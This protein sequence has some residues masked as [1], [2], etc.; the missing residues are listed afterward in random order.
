MKNLLVATAALAT[1]ATAAPAAANQSGSS[2]TDV[3]VDASLAPSCSFG[4]MS[5]S[6]LNVLTLSNENRSAS[7]TVPYSCNFVGNPTVTIASQSG[8][9]MPNQTAS[10]NGA[11]NVLSYRIRFGDA[12]T[13]TSG[14]AGL[15]AS[16]F[17]G[18]LSSNEWV[19]TTVANNTNFPILALYLDD[20]LQIAGSYSDVLT[21][22]VAP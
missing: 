8:G 13:P 11:A 5:A 15:G 18:G 6:G 16:T 1:I 7:M 17:V 22:T 9:L 3:V 12:A 19:A 14:M 10:A 4:L 20:T 21:F 2:S